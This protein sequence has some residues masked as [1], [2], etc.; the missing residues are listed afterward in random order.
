[1]NTLIETDRISLRAWQDKDRAIFADINRDHAVMTYLGPPR[2]FEQSN[3]F[4]DAQIALM[5]MEEPALWAAATKYDD[6]FIGFIGVKKINFEAHFTP[7]YEI[8][9][10]LA[11]QHWG[12]GYATEGAKAALQYAF[13]NWDMPSIHSFTVHANVKSQAVMERIGMQRVEG[14]DFDHPSLAK[15][16]PLLGHVLYKIERPSN[17]I[18]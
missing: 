7:S 10:R 16:D 14:G 4:I 15:D 2:S 1:M 5:G 11:Q 13:A 17:P 12:K 6:T 9:W 18:D 8:G 3:T